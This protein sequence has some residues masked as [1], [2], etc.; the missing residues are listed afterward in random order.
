[1]NEWNMI[2]PHWV[3]YWSIVVI[4]FWNMINPQIP[5]GAYIGVLLLPGAN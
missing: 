3:L 5:S 1:M 2:N 4:F